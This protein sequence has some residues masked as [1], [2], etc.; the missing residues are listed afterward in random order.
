M[1]SNI[2]SI[3]VFLILGLSLLIIYNS[4]LDIETKNQTIKKGIYKLSL[5]QITFTILSFLTLIVGY[6]YSDF[7]L[8]NVY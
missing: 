6:I 8:V 4:Y 5:L 7:S 2:G 3:L 1:L